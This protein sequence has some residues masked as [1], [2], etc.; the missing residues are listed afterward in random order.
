MPQSFTAI[1]L[2]KLAD[3]DIAEGNNVAENAS[4]LVGQTFG[5]ADAPLAHNS[6]TWNVVGNSGSAYDMNNMSAN[7]R[8]S[9]DGGK[10]QTFD[11]TSVYHAT[12]TYFDGTSANISAVVAQDVDGNTYLVPEFSANADQAAL[13]AGP[14][15]S[16]TFNSLAGNRYSGMVSSREDWDLVPCFTSGTLIRTRKGERPVETLRPGDWVETLDHGFQTVR[17]VGLRRVQAVGAFAPVLFKAG[18]LGNTRDLLVSQQHRMLIQSWRL[19]LHTGQNEALAP[20]KHLINGHDIIL[21]PSGVVTYIHILFDQ[22]ELLWS[23]G[24]LSESF[25]PGAQS[26]NALE[27]SARQEILSLFPEISKQGTVAYGPPARPLLSAFET[28]TSAA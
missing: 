8:F 11:G 10:P 3:I 28:R 16:I 6:V 4:A 5:H 18:A 12:V 19:E 22:H 17:W 27:Q 7:D 2:G 9:I 15:H 23:E 20:A 26:W 1:S 24:C 25:H 21:K 13:E 14:I